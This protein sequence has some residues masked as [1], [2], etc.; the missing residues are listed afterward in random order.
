MRPI[1]LNRGGPVACSTTLPAALSTTVTEA[2]SIFRWPPGAEKA[3]VLGAVLLLLFAAYAVTT[4]A[5]AASKGWPDG[6]GDS[7]ALWSW[8]RFV[9]EHTAASI[10]DPATLRSTQL[11]L[12]M[13]PAHYHPF[14]YPPSYLLVLWPLG[15]LPGWAMCAALIVVT[16]PLYLWATV[17]RNWRSPALLFALAAPTTTI[18]IVCGQSSFLAAAFLAGGLRLAAGNP[19]VGGMLLGFLTYKPQLGLLVPVALV[20]ARMWRTFAAALLTAC[21]LVLLTTM[22]FGGAIWPAW[23]A[24]LPA[25]SHNVPILSSKGLHLMPTIFGAIMQWGAAPAMA[26]LPQYAGTAVAAALVWVLFRAGPQ[27]LAGA[28]LLVAALLATPYAFAYDMPIVATAVIWVVAERHRAGDAFGTG[29]LFIL[30]LAMIAPITLVDTNPRYP[31]P[32]LSLILSLGVIV[33]RRRRLGG[34]GAAPSHAG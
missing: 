6:F 13:D 34:T 10:Y 19:I 29:E 5:V 9:D 26:L 12:G 30:V 28:G 15:H 23:A 7:F 1:S 3:R 21:G 33:Q 32:L 4:L 27:P 14:A 11:A 2:A 18:E 25:F 16:L 17:G 24:A 31:L 22:L 8:G 20:S